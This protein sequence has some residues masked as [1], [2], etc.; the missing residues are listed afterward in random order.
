MQYKDE[1]IEK[2]Q[3]IIKEEHD[4][5]LSKEEA[6]EGL[7]NLVGLFELLLKFDGE[8]KQR[9]ERLKEN[10]K[11][12]HLEGT[13]YTCPI[14]GN[15]ASNEET[16]Y[17]KWGMKCLVCQKAIDQKI[18]PGSVV[19]DK[20][21]WYSK[22]DLESDFGLDRPTITRLIKQGVLKARVVPNLNGRPRTHLF[23]IKDNKD[24]LPPKKLV[25]SRFIKES[26]D[27]KEYIRVESWYKFVDPH[28]HLKG[29]KIVDYLKTEVDS[30][31][32]KYSIGPS[33][34]VKDKDGNDVTL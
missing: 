8:D 11:G 19:E 17:D 29:Y 22:Y 2:F 7:N 15:S 23:L 1:T 13:G 14:C 31:E 34:I 9:K 33:Q 21:S 12:F 20:E 10:P 26:K 28:E 27:S 30:A 24:V 3:K 4:K 18:I 16:W 32:N 6:S 5:E 25:D